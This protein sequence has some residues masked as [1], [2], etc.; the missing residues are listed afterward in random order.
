MF[1]LV[2]GYMSFSDQIRDRSGE[3]IIHMREETAKYI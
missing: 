1:V 3:T 2:C